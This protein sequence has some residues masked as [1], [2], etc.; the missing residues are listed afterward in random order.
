MLRGRRPTARDSGV[1]ATSGTSTAVV[2]GAIAVYAVFDTLIVGLPT[3][4]LAATYDSLRVFAV[5]ALAIVLLNVACCTWVDEHWAAWVTGSGAR[6]EKR[7]QKMR[8]RTSL[9]KPIGWIE[10]G[11]VARYVLAAA[12]VNAILVVGSARVI[13]GRPVGPR[14][15]RVAALSY[16]LIFAG[17]YS[18]CGYMLGRLASALADFAH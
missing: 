17:V 18:L 12:I 15:I 10:E 3:L 8:T 13:T 16:G 7:L 6:V 1:T 9:Q 14:R 4:V 5:A 11:T 2:G